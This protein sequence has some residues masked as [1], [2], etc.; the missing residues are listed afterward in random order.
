MKSVVFLLVCVR[1]W[2]LHVI[3]RLI[4]F[5]PGVMRYKLFIHDGLLSVRCIKGGKENAK[6]DHKGLYAG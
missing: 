6:D 1:A 2:C 4:A 3:T 5:Y